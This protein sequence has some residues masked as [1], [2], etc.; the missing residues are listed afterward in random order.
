MQS[1]DWFPPRLAS[2]FRHPVLDHFYHPRNAG[3]ASNYT[4]SYLEQDNPWR[5][6]LLF[7]LRITQ[8]KIEE[9]RFKAQ[10]CVTTTACAS[11]LTEMAQG[12]NVTEALALTPEQLSDALGGL[13]QEKMYCAD[14]VMKTLRRA[15]QTPPVSEG[16]M[17]DCS[18]SGSSC[19]TGDTP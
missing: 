9:V 5:V 12:R 2:R 14:L 18:N 8:G 1:R 4:H 15:I 17:L 13:P 16:A 6:R 11:K 7:T 19:R 3:I 10:S